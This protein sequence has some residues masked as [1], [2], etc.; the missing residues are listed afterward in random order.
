MTVAQKKQTSCTGFTLV[1]LLVVIAIIGILVAMLLPAV[2]AA[3]EAARRMQCTN[4]MKQL[5]IALHNYHSAY[6]TFPSNIN[7]PGSYELGNDNWWYGSSF[8]V[9]LLP[10]LEEGDLFGEIDFSYPLNTF[11]QDSHPIIHGKELEDYVVTAYVCPSDDRSGYQADAGRAMTNYVGSM[12]AQ[13][14]ES[15][16]GCNLAS[17]VGDGGTRYDHDDD[18]EDWFSYTGLG[19][20]CNHV[21]RGNSRA[22]CPW[23]KR[24]SGVFARS[25]WAARIHDIKDG[26]SKTIAMGE[27]RPWCSEWSWSDGWTQAEGTWFATTGPINY[28]TCP[29][30]DGVPIDTNAGGPCND[31]RR[32]YSTVN[33]FKSRHPGGAHFLLADGSVRF[34]VDDIDHTN[35]QRLGDRQDGEMLDGG[36]L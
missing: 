13:L 22:D 24:V 30:E 2:Q 17:I 15:G 9:H 27:I 33:G 6:N 21:E 3:R 12:G 32:A 36:A 26:T 8:L 28:P 35:Y 19:D 18:G 29:G 4:N 14:M 23:P 25:S 16:S 7:N 11:W 1:E 20:P 10:Y 31:W 5:G 34:L